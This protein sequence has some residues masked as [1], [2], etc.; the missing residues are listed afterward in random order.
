[1]V[2]HSLS[3]FDRFNEDSRESATYPTCISWAQ[4]ML[5]PRA[6]CALKTLIKAADGGCDS[7]PK[8][9]FLWIIKACSGRVVTQCPIIIG[10]NTCFR[11]MSFLT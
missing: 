4:Q 3:G 5:E 1:M 6:I 8:P 11:G 9:R 7:T 2:M 10:N